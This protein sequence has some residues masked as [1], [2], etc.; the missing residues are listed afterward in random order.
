MSDDSGD[1]SEGV[2]VEENENEKENEDNVKE[3]DKYDDEA[4]DLSWSS[5]D[6][7]GEEIVISTVTAEVTLSLHYRDFCQ[8]SLFLFSALLFS[9]SHLFSYDP[10]FFSYFFFLIFFLIFLLIFLLFFF[11]FE[12]SFFFFFPSPF[13]LSFVIFFVFFLLFSHPLFLSHPPRPF[14]TLLSRS[15]PHKGLGDCLVFLELT[16]M[17]VRVGKEKEVRPEK[18]EEEEE[19]DL[20]EACIYLIIFSLPPRRRWRRRNQRKRTQPRNLAV[21]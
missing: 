11:F 18:E 3:E 7:E 2:E 1:S 4:D 13:H 20:M 9:F 10:F 5:S 6:D 21:V 15:H 17:V 8:P 14:L 19:V 16:K 12:L